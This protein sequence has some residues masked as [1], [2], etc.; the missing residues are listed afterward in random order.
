MNALPNVRPKIARL[1]PLL[2][3]DQDG[4]VVAAVRAIERLLQGAGADWHDLTRIVAGETVLPFKI[5]AFSGS[6]PEPR[7][8]HLARRCAERRD[9]NSRDAGFVASLIGMPRSWSP[10]SRQR[11][12]LADI[13]ARMGEAA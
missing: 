12:W 9:L 6:S 11:Q 5:V 3:S 8:R 10:T 7:W 2:A 13:A 4:E 1:L